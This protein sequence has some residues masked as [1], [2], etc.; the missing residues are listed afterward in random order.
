MNTNKRFVT[1]GSEIKDFITHRNSTSQSIRISCAI[2]T[3]YSEED[4]VIPIHVVSCII[5]E[6][7]WMR[8]PKY[9]IIGIA[10]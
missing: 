8:K 7:L 3:G 5:G 9:Y 10:C 4:Q 2:S 6:E 1:Q